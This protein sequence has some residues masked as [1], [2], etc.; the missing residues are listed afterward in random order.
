MKSKLFKYMKNIKIYLKK[1]M[2]YFKY[3]ELT[4]IL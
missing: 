4:M 2:R 3:I 1:A